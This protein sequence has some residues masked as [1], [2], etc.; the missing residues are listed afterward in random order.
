MSCWNLFVYLTRSHN[1]QTNVSDWNKIWRRHTC[2]MLTVD[3][4]HISRIVNCS[5]FT[6][7][8]RSTK[9]HKRCK[10]PKGRRPMGLPSKHHA[11]YFLVW[12]AWLIWKD[13]KLGV[14]SLLLDFAHWMLAYENVCVGS[15][16]HQTGVFEGNS[17]SC[18]VQLHV[19]HAKHQKRPQKQLLTVLL[20]FGNSSLMI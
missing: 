19:G 2:L 13:I 15:R 8:I 1:N 7:S 14:T 11:K 12:D 10:P 20:E 16:Q 6:N 17:Q 5:P 9:Y 18:D 3:E 4:Y